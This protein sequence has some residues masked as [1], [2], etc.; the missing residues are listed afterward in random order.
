M[1]KNNSQLINIFQGIL[2]IKGYQ[3]EQDSRWKWEKTQSGLYKVNLKILNLNQLQE[4]GGGLIDNFKNLALTFFAAFSVIKGEMSMG[5]LVSTQYIIG[6]L[7]SPLNNIV[8]FV[9]NFQLA[10]LSFIRLNDIY[11]IKED[12]DSEN[13]LEFFP[14]HKSISFKNVSFKY[15]N[16]YT[17]SIKN[18]NLYF[19][20]GKK[21]GIVGASGSG[22]STIVKLALN[23]YKQYA[24]EILIGTSNINSISPNQIRKRMGFVMQE[25]KLLNGSILYNITLSDDDYDE[26]KLFNAVDLAFIRREIENLQ[27]GYQTLVG[28]GGEGLST[29]QKQRILIARAV[30]TKPDYLIF[31]EA[32]N[33]L[34]SNVEKR[35]FDNIDIYLPE[36]TRIIISHRLSPIINCDTILMLRDGQV[37][38]AGDHN[39]LIARK[40]NYYNHFK[41]QALDSNEVKVLASNTN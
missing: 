20:E 15:P 1:G 13:Q 41:L 19:H 21:I 11:Q 4:L 34:E 27:N 12:A 17:F 33:A 32:S 3:V 40:G 22:K 8:G 9:N 37:I 10:Y 7:N 6:N 25:S 30:Y 23:L 24:G 26:E 31:D 35:I 29:G 2:D 36:S 18:I 39:A 28:E 16:A 14:S 5:M 38:E